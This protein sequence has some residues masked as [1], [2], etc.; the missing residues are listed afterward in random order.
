[1]HGR[2]DIQTSTPPNPSTHSEAANGRAGRQIAG[3]L[4]FSFEGEVWKSPKSP[5]LFP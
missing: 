5:I 4:V 2:A 1:M 3:K